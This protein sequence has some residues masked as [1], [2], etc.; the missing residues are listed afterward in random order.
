MIIGKLLN[1][2][3]SQ[4]S[5]CKVRITVLFA[6]LI[7]NGKWIC[8]SIKVFFLKVLVT[9]NTVRETSHSDI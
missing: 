7:I 8:V 9:W 6:M 5:L 4:S 2:S 1:L 3:E